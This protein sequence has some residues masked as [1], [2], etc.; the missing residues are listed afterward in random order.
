VRTRAFNGTF[1]RS[2]IRGVMVAVKLNRHSGPGRPAVVTDFGL[3]A[4]AAKLAQAA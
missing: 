4:Y 1:G 2:V 3:A